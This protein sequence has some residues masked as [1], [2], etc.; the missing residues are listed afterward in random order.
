MKP[1]DFKAEVEQTLQVG[2]FR[3][4]ASGL[5]ANDTAIAS[6][7]RLFEFVIVNQCVPCTCLVQE[8]GTISVAATEGGMEDDS[9]VASLYNM[10][11]E[12]SGARHRDKD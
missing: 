1:S 3:P 12:L 2:A 9:D 4:Y 10:T 5:Q 11:M 6:G 7:T 8:L